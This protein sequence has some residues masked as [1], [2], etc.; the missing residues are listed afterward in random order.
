[1]KKYFA[2]AILILLAACGTENAEF[3]PI[4]K[5]YQSYRVE[6]VESEDVTNVQASFRI[7]SPFG[8]KFI[9]EDPV[10]FLMNGRGMNLDTNRQYPYFYQ[11][12]GRETPIVFVYDNPDMEQRTE[13]VASLDSVRTISLP[14]KSD[15]ISLDSTVVIRWGGP[16][17]ARNER[18]TITIADTS[19]KTVSQFTE[20]F[21]TNSLSFFL[22][23]LSPLK[24]GPGTLE[25]SRRLEVSLDDKTPYGG[26]LYMALSTGPSAVVLKKKKAD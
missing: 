12:D 17:I 4:T 15:T 10:S 16:S 3:E 18:I 25:I 5:I 1:M 13:I 22:R 14:V 2:F 9:I 21:N 6:Y 11:F 8:E 26:T 20:I 7:K 23:D 24:P 19:G